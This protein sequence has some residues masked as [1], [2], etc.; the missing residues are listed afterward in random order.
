MDR[1]GFIGT[2]AGAVG[3]WFS[4]RG[5][6]A[7]AATKNSKPSLE[8]STETWDLPDGPQEVE[9]FDMTLPY[10]NPTLTFQDAPR[11]RFLIPRASEDEMRFRGHDTDPE[12]GEVKQVLHNRMHQ[13]LVNWRKAPSSPNP[14]AVCLIVRQPRGTDYGMAVNGLDIFKR[15]NLLMQAPASVIFS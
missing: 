9:V 12:P 8:V 10:D 6:K 5:P 4:L 2:A 15:E 1:R 11:H 14:H 3:A 7:K 13:V